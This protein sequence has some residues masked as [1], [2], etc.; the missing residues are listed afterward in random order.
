MKIRFTIVASALAGLAVC[1]WGAAPYASLLRAHR[2]AEVERLADA[3]L[4]RDPAE[5]DA[6]A[7]KSEA[8]MALDHEGRTEEALRLAEQCIAANAQHSNCYLAHGNA[9]GAKAQHAGPIAA[10]GLAT[11]IRDD[12]L[13]AVELDPHNTDARFALLDYY[14]QAPALVGGGRARARA[15]AAQTEAVSP[16]AGRLMQ[17]QLALA[18]KDYAQAQAILHAVRT[19]GDEMAA[20]RQRELMA[21]LGQHYRADGKHA[22]GDSVMRDVQQRFPEAGATP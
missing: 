17:A 22:D 20:D 14:I 5:P 9:L 1:A 13:K 4:A 21:A 15:L 3:A 18:D 19:G 7:A 8:I 6:L 16:A 10:M 12:F 2:F 11:R